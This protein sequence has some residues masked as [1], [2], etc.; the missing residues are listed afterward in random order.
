MW[1]LLNKAKEQKVRMKSFKLENSLSNSHDQKEALIGG[2][3]L[4]LANISI[5]ITGLIF[6]II[7]SKMLGLKLLG[8]ISVIINTSMLS[9]ALA[10]SGITIAT[11]REIAK[12]GSSIVMELLIATLIFS[13]I[14]LLLSLALSIYVGYIRYIIIINCITVLVIMYSV[15]IGL[16]I[17]FAF[18]RTCFI[19]VFIACIVK[20]ITTLA[21][22]YY[23]LGIYSPIYGHILYLIIV[24]S[25]TFILILKRTAGIYAQSIVFKNLKDIIKFTLSNYIYVLSNQ[26]LLPLTVYLFAYIVKQPQDVGILYLSLMIVNILFMVVASF[27]N[28][29]LSLSMRKSV[30]IF[31]YSLKL[32]LSLITIPLII[33]LALS[34]EVIHI[35]VKCIGFY[36]SLILKIL[37]LS[38]VPL[39]ALYALLTKLNSLGNLLNILSL[40]LIRFTTLI[41]LMFTLSY[42]GILGAALSFLLANTITLIIFSYRDKS[43]LKASLKFWV[44]YIVDFIIAEFLSFNMVLSLTTI[45]IF[46]LVFSKLLNLEILE[47]LKE[48]IKRV[49]VKEILKK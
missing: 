47:C 37:L 39:S 22:L 2:I 19:I 25:C 31:E 18:F 32:G 10:S 21:L 44:L 17:G 30:D 48:V 42:C 26:A 15:A 23:N 24:S 46:S 36:T 34:N 9:A 1:K 5:S 11:I 43:I 20:I 7:V 29:S 16:L 40:G 45:L 33:C 13:V 49:V 12:N 27:L 4:A 35:F 14:G 41:I 3:W 28:A 38:L 6:W 8:I